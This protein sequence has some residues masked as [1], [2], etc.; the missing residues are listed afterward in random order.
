MEILLELGHITMVRGEQERLANKKNDWFVEY[1]ERMTPAEIFAGVPA[2][3]NDLRQRGQLIG[4]ASSSKNAPRVIALLGL[5]DA[6][7]AMVDGTMIVHTKPDP[8]IFLL[9]ARK[10]NV[11]PHEC[12][13]F[14]DAEAG[15][16]SA[17]AAGMACVGIGSREQLHQA[18]VV[19]SATGAFDPV[20]LTT[21]HVR[22]PR[23]IP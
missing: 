10:L 21:L 4:L 19:L 9:A 22:Q 5:A 13:V 14:E 16:E 18:D 3:L 6:F 12:L 11:A 2:L 23:P 1:V 17:L 7:D 15:V 20:L 8:E